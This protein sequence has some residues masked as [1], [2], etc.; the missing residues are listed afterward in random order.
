MKF[1][2]ITCTHNSA[3]YLAD[4]INSVKNQ[5]FS[6]WEHIFIDGHS[7]DETVALITAYQQQFPNQVK[8]QQQEPRGI[9]PAMNEGIKLAQG[10]YL[11]HLHADDQLYDET[12][13]EKVQVFLQANNYPDWIFGREKHIND[14]GVIGLYPRFKIYTAD[15]RTP[16]GSYFLGIANYVRHQTV[17][18]K[19]EVFKKYGLFRE[20]LQCTMDV[21]MWLRLKDQTRWLFFDSL[22][23]IYR[24]HAQAQSTNPNNR[25]AND[26][27]YFKVH[28]EYLNFFNFSIFYLFNLLLKLRLKLKK[29]VD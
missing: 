25:R 12:V 21:E 28:R 27:E 5:K 16:G 9:A 2:I 13:L 8:L 4:H 6:D 20:D 10:D 15:S 22:I 7:Q 24:H 1:S 23:A 29:H 19:P 26:Q 11:I 17:F 14:Q 18:I 3:R